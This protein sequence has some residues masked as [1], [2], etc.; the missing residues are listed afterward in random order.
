M[1]KFDTFSSLSAQYG[2]TV[3][4]SVTAQQELVTAAAAL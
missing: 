2:V 1:T 3:W 4:P